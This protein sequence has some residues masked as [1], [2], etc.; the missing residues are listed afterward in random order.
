MSW[1][2]KDHNGVNLHPQSWVLADNNGLER[3]HQ[4]LTKDGYVA[5]V[6]YRSASW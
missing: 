4:E 1:A 5:V 2:C 3:S 6:F